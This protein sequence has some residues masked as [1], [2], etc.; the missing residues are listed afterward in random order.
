M[1]NTGPII[2]IFPNPAADRFNIVYTLDERS[3]VKI[4]LLNVIGQV[5]AIQKAEQV[6]YGNAIFNV[7]AFPDGIYT[8]LFEGDG[9]RNT[10]KLVIAH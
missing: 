3:N 7:S 8:W 10:G 6:I 9:I 5:V 4:T 2:N 1:Q